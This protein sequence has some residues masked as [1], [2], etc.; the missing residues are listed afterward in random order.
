MIMIS[1]PMGN[2]P[3]WHEKYQQVQRELTAQGYEV[4]PL[5]YVNMFGT[6]P[7]YFKEGL[8]CKSTPLFY[9]AHSFYRMSLCDT[10]YFC[11]GWESARGCRLEHQAAQDYGLKILYEP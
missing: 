1:L 6:R 5:T 10:I 3:H 2:N 8:N 7:P 11:H 9:M 4:A